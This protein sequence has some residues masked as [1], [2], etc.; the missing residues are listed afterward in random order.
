M[1]AGSP[2]STGRIPRTPLDSEPLDLALDNL[3]GDLAQIGRQVIA[4]ALKTAGVD[5]GRHDR[6]IADWLGVWELS[7]AVTIASW[8]VR[9]YDAGRATAAQ[10]RPIG[11]DSQKGD[12]S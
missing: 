3:G 9:G 2:M 4:D 11:T 12:R 6:R 1:S 5:L 10:T 8:I 7:T